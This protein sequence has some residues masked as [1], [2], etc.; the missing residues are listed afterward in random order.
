MQLL[1]ATSNPHKVEEVRAI[2][3]PAGF[4]VVG[5]DSLEVQ[6]PEPVEDGAT[7]A[8]NARIKAVF[9]AKAAGRLCLADDS[10]LEVDALDGGPGVLSA[11][12]AGTGETR[13][14][15]TAANNARLL[16][17]LENVPDDR[18]AGRFVCAMCLA[19]A[20][21]RILAETRGTFPGVIARSPR[22]TSGFGYDPLVYLPAMDRTVAELTAEEK[23]AR[24]HRGEAMR[25]MAESLTAMSRN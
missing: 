12:Y 25:R 22:G 8:D 9:Y 7:F 10:G 18:R 16:R 11:R 24:S 19:D 2:L 14:E 6:P 20:E 1:F 17:E 5:L 21:G 3:A 15:Q 13:S 23:N 4:D